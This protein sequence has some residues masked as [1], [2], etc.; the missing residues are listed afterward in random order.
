[1]ISSRRYVAWL[2]VVLA[3]TAVAVVGVAVL[4]ARPKLGLDL[5]GGLSVVLQARGENVNAETLDKTVEII[6]QR[7]DSIGA[8]E[9]DI[10]RAGEDNV[11]VQLPDIED[12]QRALEIIGKTAQ[13]QFREVLDTRDMTPEIAAA[14]AAAA[15]EG[16]EEGT[17]AY[18]EFVADHIS[19]ET[20]WRLS[21]EDPPGEQVTFAG[22]E[23]EIW[24]RLGPAEIRGDDVADAF[25]QPP[26]GPTPT[27]SVQLT[28]TSEGA[29][30]FE[31]VTTRLAPTAGQPGGGLLA[32]VL[33]R[34]VQ[35]APVVQDPIPGGQAQ[36]TG[37]FSEGEARDLGLV[38]Q[39]GALPI[40][41]EAIQTQ[42]VS[43]TLGAASL[44]AGLL[45]GLIGLTLVAIY[46]LAFYRLL[47]LVTLIGLGIFGALVTGVIG[48]IGIYQGFTLTLPGIA[49]LIVSVGIAADSSI[50][51]FERVKDELKEGK[52]FRSAVDRGFKSAFRTN[53]AGN[54]VALAAAIVLWLLAVGPVR[55]FALTLGISVVIDIGIL[56]FYTH[57]AVALISRNRRLAQLRA[58]GMRE[59]VPEA[60]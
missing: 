52:T 3:L 5:K 19:E 37:Q 26:I 44:R 21:E 15:E 8:Q 9:P 34:T 58:V 7:V 47:G 12:P 39:T 1:M 40:E 35:S 29:Q 36:I 22:R 14:E 18:R 48:G 54:A 51:Y 33:D 55:G 23:G 28:L 20:G 50:I 11:I 38:L 4:G 10:S 16:L 30:R 25:A 57:P 31:E 17:E 43:P 27:W 53:L 24:Y 6:R 59:V 49:G 46:M 60:A 32:I 45:A 42:N 41:L 2:A 13:L 56:Y